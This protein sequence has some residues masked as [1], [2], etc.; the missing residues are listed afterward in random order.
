MTE[1]AA[2]VVQG[3]TGAVYFLGTGLCRMASRAWD[4]RYRGR[5]YP[6]VIALHTLDVVL[7]LWPSSAPES[8]WSCHPTYR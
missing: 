2:T 5:G 4:T 8:S 1:K 6:T 7:H 3:A